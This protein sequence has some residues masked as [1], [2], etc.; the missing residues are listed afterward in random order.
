MGVLVLFGLVGGR[1]VSFSLEGVK[2]RGL[3]PGE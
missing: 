2:V 3:W 1:G